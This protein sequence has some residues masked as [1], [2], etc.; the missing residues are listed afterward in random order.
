MKAFR[1]LLL[2]AMLATVSVAMAAAHPVTPRVDRREARQH[3]RIRE[4]VRSGQLTPREA[5]RLRAGQVHVHRMERR[6]KSDGRVTLRERAR[7]ERAQNRQSRHIA[8]LKHNG[9]SI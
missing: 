7:L 5:A 9:R 3:M 8:L 2:A 4:G 6:A 1:V